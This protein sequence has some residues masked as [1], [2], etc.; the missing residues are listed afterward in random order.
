MERKNNPPDL[1]SVIDRFHEENALDTFEW[2]AL[3]IANKDGE[4]D[5]EGWDG[6]CYGITSQWLFPGLAIVLREP[7]GGLF[8][9][10]HS[11]RVRVGGVVVVG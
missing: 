6:R 4:K 10:A 11:F 5:A 2:T 7:E 9:D 3:I 1:S 8:V